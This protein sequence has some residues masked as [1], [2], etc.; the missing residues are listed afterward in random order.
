MHISIIVAT[1]ENGVIGNK[2]AI[3]WN[4][5]ADMDYFRQKTLSHPIIMGRKTYESIGRLLPNRPNIIIT[6][7]ENINIR[8][9]E[10]VQTIEEAIEKAKA[11]GDEEIFIIGGEA[12]YKLAM[13]YIDR[14]YLTKI[15]AEVEG[16]KY[17][18]F[19]PSGWKETSRQAH[20]AGE[21]NQYAYEF[22]VFDKQ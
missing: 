17:F 18:K 8:G 6:R 1:D 22:L 15:H 12:I 14:I 16:D 3:P 7:D 2:G 9:A 20:P 11:Y 13:P 5:P 21:K 4:M 19:D 10:V